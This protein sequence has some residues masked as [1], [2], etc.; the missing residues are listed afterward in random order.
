M[1]FNGLRLAATLAKRDGVELRVFLMGDAVVAALA[2]HPGVTLCYERRPEPV[3]WPY[4]LY[5]MIHARKRCEAMAILAGDALLAEG[6]LLIARHPQGSEW[7][8]RRAGQLAT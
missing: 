4:R 5:C 7:A 1:P 6:M 3:L 8:A 2:A